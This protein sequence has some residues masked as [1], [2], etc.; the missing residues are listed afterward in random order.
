MALNFPSNP[1]NN[2]IYIDSTSGNRYRFNAIANVWSYAANNSLQG[3]SIDTQVI[4]NDAGAANGHPGLTFR[5]A[6]NTLTANTINAFSVRVTGNLYVGTNT[7]IVTNDA[8]MAQSFFI[9]DNGSPIAVS[10]GATTNASFTVANAAYAAVNSAFGVVNAAFS[11]ANNVA[12]QIAPAF[13]TA[14]AAF[15]VA[16]GAFGVANTVTNYLPLA[17]GTMTGALNIGTST[18]LSFGAA[19]RQMINLFN[20]DYAIGIQNNTQYY[21]SASRFSWHRGGVHSGTENDPGAGGTSAMTLDSSSNLT[22]VGSMRSP[23]FYDSDNTGF[24]VDAASTSVL[25][26]ATISIL[27]VGGVGRSSSHCIGANLSGAIAW[28]NSQLEIRNN[29]G[30]NVGIAFH[31]AGFTSVALYHDAGSNLRCS[32]ILIGDTDARAP[33]FYD[34]NDTGWYCNPNATSRLATLQ[35]GVN[36]WHSSSEGNQRYYFESS[37]STYI[38]GYGYWFVRVGG[39]GHSGIAEN[40]TR[41]LFEG[42]GNIYTIGNIIAY[43]SDKRLKKNI[44]KITDWRQIINGINGYRFE[45]NDI[46]NTLLENSE[47]GVQVGLIAQEVESVLPQATTIQLTQYKDNVNGKLI[48]R[49]DINYDPE[50]PYKTVKEDKLIPVM[51]EAIKGLLDITDKQQAQIDELLKRTTK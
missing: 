15:G 47:P 40:N 17:G 33:I 5:G 44:N 10:T 36:T 32:G 46:G 42:A 20:T 12:P 7:V 39:N 34:L 25:N 8:V 9:M 35:Q 22:A 26:G 37:G 14:N 48:P 2:Q 38:Y 29:N 41:S 18:N 1:S 49:D 19:V 6:A 31:R 43:W 27:E 21:R 11:S 51:I 13:N 3:G 30:N 45:W 24:Y 16:N 50:D 4:Y 23:I 28:N